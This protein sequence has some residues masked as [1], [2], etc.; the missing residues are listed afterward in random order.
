VGA[1]S[2]ASSTLVGK[3]A[4][5]VYLIRAIVGE[6]MVARTVAVA[7]NVC[8]DYA[9]VAAIDRCDCDQSQRRSHRVNIVTVSEE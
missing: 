4:D 9:I 5:A 8:L 1:Q 6:T 3:S 2:S 7:Y